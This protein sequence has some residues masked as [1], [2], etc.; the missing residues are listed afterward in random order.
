MTLKKLI[1]DIRNRLKEGGYISEMDICNRVV[2]RL[3]KKLGWSIYDAW[4]VIFEYR[5]SEEYKRIDL[6]LCEPEAKPVIFI[7]IKTFEH[8]L[9][10]HDKRKSIKQLAEYIS[11]FQDYYHKHDDVPIAILTD[12]QKW[13]FFHPISGVDW[14]EHPVCELDLIG[15][16][17]KEC[18]EILDRY[19]NYKSIREGKAI[20]AI[21][22]DYQNKGSLPPENTVSFTRRLRVK[23]HDGEV[24]DCPR[25][26]DT[27]DKV[28]EKL[29]VGAEELTFNKNNQSNIWQIRESLIRI[30]RWIGKPLRIE[31][32]TDKGK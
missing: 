5:V 13:I 24:I 4:T 6:A 22:N 28:I 8:I 26:D 3:L 15:N 12:G 1:E 18:V 10:D 9:R 25:I 19:L 29:E 14:K 7:E 21:K 30:G 20:K 32:Y 31:R 11:D 17:V 2:V 23:I 16:D 27:F